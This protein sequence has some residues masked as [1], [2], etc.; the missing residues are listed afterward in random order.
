MKTEERITAKHVKKSEKNKQLGKPYTT[1]EETDQIGNGR[2][3]SKSSTRPFKRRSRVKK[4][5]PRLCPN[6]HK[7]KVIKATNIV[8]VNEK[9]ILN[10]SQHT[11]TEEHKELLTLGPKFCPTPR[12]VNMED[13]DNSIDKWMNN[14]RWAYKFA[15]FTP[16]SSQSVEESIRIQTERSLLPSSNR[17]APTNNN[18][19]LELYLSLVYKDLKNMDISQYSHDNLRPHLRTALNQLTSWDDTVVRYFDKGIGWVIDECTNYVNK[20]ESQLSDSTTFTLVDSNTSIVTE[21]ELK[22]TNWADTYSKTGDISNKLANWICKENGRPGYNYGNYKVHKPEKNFPCRMITS[23]CGSP[24]ENLA[25]FSEFYL[26]PL[27]SKL[28]Y[29]TKDNTHFLQKLDSFNSSF[30]GCIEYVIL[31]TWD[32]ES[33]YPSIDNQMGLAAFQDLLNQRE[34]LFPSIECIYEA[35]KICLENNISFFNNNIY[36]QKSGTAMGPH[37]ACSYADIS[38]G[39]IYLEVN[40]NPQFKLQMWSRFKNDIF[41]PWTG[42][43]AELIQF[44]NWIN[45]L[46]RLYLF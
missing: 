26:H 5:T 38:I 28:Q 7:R 42:T 37:N 3:K 36:V 12:S 17:T 22:I 16:P 31:A 44:T 45:T 8:P 25:S 2:M 4:K 46:V 33:M 34:V 13:Y 18:P 10:L 35:T 40:S 6:K 11:L 15:N 20:V 19:A 32:I 1:L 9:M 14:I 27:V 41:E 43:E 30:N 39:P 24:V 21:I 23:G 29:V